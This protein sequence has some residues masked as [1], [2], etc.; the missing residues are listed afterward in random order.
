MEK[1][2]IIISQFPI[3]HR[4]S[5][6]SELEVLEEVIMVIN[7]ILMTIIF[8]FATLNFMEKLYLINKWFKLK[9]LINLIKLKKINSKEKSLQKKH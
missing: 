4:N 2:I 8:S 1:V 6:I 9:N 3:I 7:I 5:D